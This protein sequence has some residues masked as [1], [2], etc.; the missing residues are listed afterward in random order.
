[1]LDFI[2]DHPKTMIALYVL[3]VVLFITAPSTH[4]SYD[5]CSYQSTGVW[6]SESDYDQCYDD[7]IADAYAGM[8]SGMNH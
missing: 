1:M 3:S 7:A 4:K 6:L 2:L 5:P 8:D